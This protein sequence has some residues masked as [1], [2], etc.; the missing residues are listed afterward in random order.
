M[1]YLI[2]TLAGLNL[3]AT[4]A[5]LMGAV[6]N[7]CS[8]LALLGILVMGMLGTSAIAWAAFDGRSPV[9]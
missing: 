1:K 7:T 6:G 4:S 8:N 3:L 5:Y 9:N 2:A